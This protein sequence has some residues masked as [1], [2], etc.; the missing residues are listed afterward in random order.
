MPRSAISDR[1]CDLTKQ[2]VS[3][4]GGGLVVIAGPR[5]GPRELYQTSLADMLPVIIDPG[6]DIRA[7]PDYPEFRLRLTPLA[8]SKTFM[9]LGADQA[10]NAKAWYNLG[11]LPWYQ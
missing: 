8:A 10:E 3:Q 6:A 7:A 4:L 2:F 5:F 1:F 9:Q 11:K